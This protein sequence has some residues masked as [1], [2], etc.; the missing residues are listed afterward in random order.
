MVEDHRHDT[1]GDD[2]HVQ[3]DVSKTG[4]RLSSVVNYS[5]RC[6]VTGFVQGIPLGSGGTFAVDAP[7]PDDQG[8][9]V[10][11]G[12][13]TGPVTASGTWTVTTPTC[14]AQGEFTAK[15]ST[16]HFLVGNPFEYAPERIAENADIGRITYLFRRYAAAG[17]F[18]P[19]RARA[20]GYSFRG[21]NGGCPDMVHARKRGTMFWGKVLDPSAPQSLMY[22]CGSD[23]K[24]VLAGAMFRA[25]GDVRPRSYGNLIQ[26]HKHAT[27]RTANWMT[28]L[29]LTRDMRSTWATCAPFLAYEQAGMF[30][31]EEYPWIMETKPCTDTP[32]YE[33]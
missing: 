18:T 19:A 8:R 15:D 12:A 23:R 1:G 11:N 13:F 6:K 33:G 20:M 22:W 27:S 2:W 14:T 17:R 32:G 30:S 9:F 31:Y 10:V 4:T 25:P 21:W 26:W 16:G 3:L 24:L 5:Q 7:L 28:H 29:W